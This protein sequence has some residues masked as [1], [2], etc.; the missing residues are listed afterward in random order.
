[1]KRADFWRLVLSGH[2]S[3]TE[4]ASMDLDEFYEALAALDLATPK[5]KPKLK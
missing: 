2:F 5:R 1:M 4:V 3:Y